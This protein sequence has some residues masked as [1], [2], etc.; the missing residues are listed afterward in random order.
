MSERLE[1]VAVGSSTDISIFVEKRHTHCSVHVWLICR[2]HPVYNVTYLI[3]QGLRQECVGVRGII[4]SSIYSK[5]YP[6]HS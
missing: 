1:A 3:F 5:V 6:V 2:R 4:T